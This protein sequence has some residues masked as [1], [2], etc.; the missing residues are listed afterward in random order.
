VTGSADETLTSASLGGLAASCPIVTADRTSPS[1]N[2][3]KLR[4]VR[5]IPHPPRWC[6]THTPT[7]TFDA[8]LLRNPGR[9]AARWHW[10]SEYHGN[11]DTRGFHHLPSARYARTILIEGRSQVSAPAASYRVLH[12]EWSV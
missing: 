1:E 4:I 10:F 2:V 5:S 6:T 8:N 12:A 9:D 11:C 7:S 3:S